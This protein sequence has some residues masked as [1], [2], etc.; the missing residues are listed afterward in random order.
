MNCRRIEELIPLYVEGDLDQSSTAGVQA[1][2][3]SC[4]ACRE[5]AA[6]YEASQAWL[7]AY[8]VPDFDEAFVDGVRRGV[9]RELAGHETR[10]PFVER[11]KGWLTPRRMAVAALMIIFM[12]LTLVIY[13]SRPRRDRDSHNQAKDLPTP[14]LEKN[15]E[16]LKVASEAKPDPGRRR[17]R[18]A[19]RR[20]LPVL[21][22][23]PR[24]PGVEPR[25]ALARQPSM[26]PEAPV[27]DG[28]PPTYNQEMLRIEFQTADPNIRIIWLTPK[29]SDPE[30]SEPMDETR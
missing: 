3:R 16:G 24:R 9:M 7:H 30:A 28:G 17:E 18:Q 10:L 27:T 22:K 19:P 20:A 2:V 11:L 21:V 8:E 12:A 26:R 1:H 4:A 23:S 25:Q 13:S 15:S 14:G 5:L 6:E 29:P